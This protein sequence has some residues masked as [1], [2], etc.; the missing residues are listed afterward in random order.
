LSVYS[1]CPARTITCFLLLKV[2]KAQAGA[3]RSGLVLPTQAQATQHSAVS[4]AMIP[5]KGCA[6]LLC[7]KVPHRAC[8]NTMCKLCCIDRKGGCLAPGHNFTALSE[9]QRGKRP[10]SQ[11]PPT[12]NDP[13]HSRPVTVSSPLIMSDEQLSAPVSFASDPDAMISAHE[14]P[15]VVL[16]TYVEKMMDEPFAQFIKETAAEEARLMALEEQE[17]QAALAASRNFNFSV[18]SSSLRPPSPSQ[19]ASSAFIPTP[20]TPPPSQPVRAPPPI[21]TTITPS[22]RRPTITTQMNPALMREYEDKRNTVAVKKGVPRIDPTITR[23]FQVVFWDIDGEGPTVHS[24]HSCPTW[25]I[26]RLS[27]APG[28]WRP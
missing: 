13:H 25:P 24:V 2:L 8:P 7:P 21:L 26:W 6:Q 19:F 3:Q 22:M 28:H 17:Y 16:D 5:T 11:L 10:Q 20:P 27:E 1:A 18:P 4:K 14:A 15:A 12:Y 23:R 9:R